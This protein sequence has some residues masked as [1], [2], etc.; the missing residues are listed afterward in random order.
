MKTRYL[1]WL[2]III[3]FISTG[4]LGWARYRTTDAFFMTHPTPW[5]RSWPYPDQWLCGWE[6]SLDAAHPLPT[7]PPAIKLRGEW[8]RVYVHLSGWMIA[9]GAVFAAGLVL[10]YSSRRRSYA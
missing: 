3:G 2:L 8:T 1:A 6:R 10:L 9:T 5:P 4:Y 7:D